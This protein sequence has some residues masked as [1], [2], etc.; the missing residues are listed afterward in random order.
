M[1]RAPRLLCAL[2]CLVLAAWTSPAHAGI[3]EGD[4]SSAGGGG[5][6]LVSGPVVSVAV[7]GSV[8]LLEGSSDCTI[9]FSRSSAHLGGTTPLTVSTT[10]DITR[11]AN[12][13]TSGALTPLTTTTT[14]GQLGHVIAVLAQEL[15]KTDYED[16]DPRAA[17]LHDYLNRWDTDQ[18]RDVLTTMYDHLGPDGTLAIVDRLGHH[19]N[20][21]GNL[22]SKDSTI[23]KETLEHLRTGLHRVSTAWSE[24]QAKVFGSQ[25]VEHAIS[26]SYNPTYERFGPYKE[27]LSW[28]LYDT[29]GAS[30]A[31]VQGA[32][33]QMDE[34]QK[35]SSRPP[36]W[37][38]PLIWDYLDY[39][40]DP[41]EAPWTGSVAST[42]MHALA[43]R[44]MHAYRFFSNH[45]D[46]ITRWAKEHA[47][48]D[49]D[50]S[51]VSAALDAASTDPKTM[52][53][54]P[55]E[56]AAIA[57][58]ALESLTSHK[59]FGTGPGQHGLETAGNLEHILE[60]YIDSIGYAYS[61]RNSTP[62][63][64]TIYFLP[65]GDIVEN[66]PKFTA[67]ALNK[68]V[69]LISREG[70]ALLKL[71]AAV[72]QAEAASLPPG[73]NL[74]Q[75]KGSTSSWGTV[76]GAI[77]KAV[78]NGAIDQAAQKDDYALAWIELGSKGAEELASLATSFAP[79]GT[80]KAAGKVAGWSSKALVEHYAS[81]A[82]STW[83]RNA[84]T[85]RADQEK[86]AAR[87]TAEY[88]LRMFFKVDEL[89]L[90]NYQQP[91]SSI[92]PDD[93]Q[94]FREVGAAVDIGNGYRF[95]N[96]EEYDSL[97]QD[98]QKDVRA[99]L[100]SLAMSVHGFD[101]DGSVRRAFN[102]PFIDYFKEGG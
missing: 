84:G 47:Y 9:R 66:I 101:L 28:L 62:G 70:Q 52:R 49:G 73:S 98:K 38:L 10:Y 44:P 89:G 88:M 97:P 39:L 86:K 85:A 69:A 1:R 83:A 74:N 58:Y 43:D 82:R 36:N 63:A 42:V 99:T 93:W 55:L 75:L 94:T 27:A 7:S 80:G 34:V 8:E 41:K 5:S 23:G 50:L 6:V 96:Q 57:S 68:A 19:I 26:P 51:D 48:R 59:D 11:T 100:L 45:E 35:S 4:T 16:G 64:D 54:H 77:T 61:S 14:K 22:G 67:G 40:V 90:N 21:H 2:A 91:G 29:K 24:G 33:E 56:A 12:D 37:H 71:R 18:H 95:I 78:G 17:M 20:R 60:T 92:K 76:E 13:G 3:K 87:A 15:A 31:L 102:D 65:Q 81:E 53:Q 46:R 25:L 72:N 30:G 32:A 79:P